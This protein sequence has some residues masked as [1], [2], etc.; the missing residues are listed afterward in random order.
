MFP[1]IREHGSSSESQ[2]LDAAPRTRISSV[3]P[4]PPPV[5]GRRLRHPQLRGAIQIHAV[6]R[7]IKKLLAYENQVKE[8][9][10]RT[11]YELN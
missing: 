9:F 5:G 8:G 11:L 6:A 1:E 2:N 10:A 3:L 4:F 7:E